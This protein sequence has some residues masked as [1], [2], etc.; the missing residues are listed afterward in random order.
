LTFIASTLQEIQKTNIFLYCY[1]ASCTFLYFIPQEDEDI[2]M[3]LLSSV[4]LILMKLITTSPYS[5]ESCSTTHK[6]GPTSIPSGFLC[7]HTKEYYYHI[8]YFY[9]KR[10][11]ILVNIPNILLSFFLYFVVTCGLQERVESSRFNLKKI[12]QKLT[13]HIYF[14]Y[15]RWN[16]IK[17]N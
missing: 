14:W 17:F 7:I 16:L 12:Q 15:Y 2:V 1:V 8:P 10:L 3:C 4:K 6:L 13:V 11:H 9:R 5:E